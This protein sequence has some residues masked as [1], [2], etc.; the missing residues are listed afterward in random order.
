[1]KTIELNQR[2]DSGGFSRFLFF[3]LIGDIVMQK[4]SIE[5]D[6]RIEDLY[7]GIWRDFTESQG[8]E[9]FYQMKLLTFQ[10]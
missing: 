10:P 7:T 8:I 4:T 5:S 6:V 2:D 3:G 1:M 9:T